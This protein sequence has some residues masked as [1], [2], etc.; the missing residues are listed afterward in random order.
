MGIQLP[1]KRGKAPPLFGPCLLWPNGWMDQDATWYGG[2]SPPRPHCVTWGAAPPPR[3]GVQQSPLFSLFGS[4]VLWPYGRPSQLLL[5]SCFNSS[6][7]LLI[8]STAFILELGILWPWTLTYDLGH[9]TWP[10]PWVSPKGFKGIC[11]PKLPK[12]DLR[13]IAKM[14]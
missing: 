11:T 13:K 9:L 1:V 7:S 2:R 4:C 3:K 5:S 12:L 8:Q 10:R 14:T 6:L